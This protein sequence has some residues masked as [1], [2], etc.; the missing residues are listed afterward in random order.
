MKS[1][2]RSRFISQEDLRGGRWEPSIRALLAEPAPPE[3]M[4]TD[5]AQIVASAI[6]EVLE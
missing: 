4:R 2:L 6:L 3:R 1:V 5:G